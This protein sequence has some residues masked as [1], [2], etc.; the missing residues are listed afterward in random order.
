MFSKDSTASHTAGTTTYDAA[1]ERAKSS[2]V[3]SIIS[4]DL[5]IIGDLKC[6]GDIMIDGTVEGDIN[7]RILTV[8]ERAKINGS[9][10]ADTVRISGT[11]KGQVKAKA[12]H[13][14][15][16]ARV[17]GDITHGTLTMEA[18]ASL[19]GQVRRLEAVDTGGIAKVAPLRPAAAS[20]QETSHSGAERPAAQ[21]LGS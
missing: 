1:G 7:C 21:N 5:K 12:V 2:G 10:V 18:G 13:L 20:T 11:I 16:S 17:T 4:T 15:K 3:A 6:N 8:G 14:D 9:V 19:E